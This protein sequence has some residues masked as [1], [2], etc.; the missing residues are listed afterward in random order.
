[1]LDRFHRNCKIHSWDGK[2]RSSRWNLFPVQRTCIMSLKR[3]IVLV[4]VFQSLKKTWR[5]DVVGGIHRSS[6]YNACPSWEISR[7]R[8]FLLQNGDKKV[9]RTW[10]YCHC[11]LQ[12]ECNLVSSTSINFVEF[13][14]PFGVGNFLDQYFVNFTM[15]RW[16]LINYNAFGWWARKNNVMLCCSIMFSFNWSRDYIFFLFTNIIL[17][18]IKIFWIYAQLNT[19]GVVLSMYTYLRLF[20]LKF[21]TK[22]KTCII[23]CMLLK[24]IYIFFFQLISLNGLI[25]I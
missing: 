6:A 7:K 4:L 17:Y 13:L 18:C 2:L 12:S 23:R 14:L 15:K 22:N 24:Y 11:T 10:A 5:W 8:N 20:K 1:M 3:R 9:G 25:I 19:T 16:L 21:Q